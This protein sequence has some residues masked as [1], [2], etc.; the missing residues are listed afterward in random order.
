MIDKEQLKK[1]KEF[2]VD[3]DWNRAF[4]GKSY[5]NKHLF[6]TVL[7]AERIA[8]DEISRGNPVDKMIIKA[9]AWL[10]DS[11]LAKD[12]HGDALC[13]QDEVIAFLEEL[14]IS[15]EDTRKIIDCIRGHD[16]RSLALSREAKIV[17]DA[18]TLEKMGPLGVV[19]ETWKRS[20]MGWT[21]E[22]ICEHLRNHLDRRKS[23]LNTAFA[24]GLAEK[25][26]QSLTP[27]FF[28]LGG[29]LSLK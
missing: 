20:Q 1:I 18:D 6:R 7:L 16:G 4:G 15:D 19:R 27:F 17:H 2:A 25:L 3:L 8:D 24:K 9:G 12:I 10:H 22:R 26:D 14:D 5:G 11:G 23:L 13:N 29:Q 21:S 28:T